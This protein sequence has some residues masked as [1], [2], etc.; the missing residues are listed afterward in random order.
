MGFPN[1]LLAR[2]L[3]D[4]FFE[5]WRDL[6][7]LSELRRQPYV[8]AGFLGLPRRRGLDLLERLNQ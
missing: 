8:N 6:L 1:I 7:D 2:L 4:R 3:A 5:A